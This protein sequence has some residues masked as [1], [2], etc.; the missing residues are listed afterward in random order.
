M[1]L[2]VAPPPPS[3]P[4]GYLENTPLFFGFYTR[5]SLDWHCL[6]TP[7][8]YLA[9]ILSILLLSFIL[10]VR[11]SVRSPQGSVFQLLFSN[12]P[13]TRT[14]VGY[15]HTWMLRKRYSM[16]VSYKIFCGWDFTIQDPDSASLKHGCIRNDLKV[17][18]ASTPI[19]SAYHL[20]TSVR[21][22]KKNWG[23]KM[24]SR[25]VSPIIL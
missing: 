16:N 10:L 23:K 25:I 17:H 3:S 11:R 18:L 22:K 8:L 7:L 21:V 20:K 9:G 12:L 15:K 13:T 14:M 1:L 24:V 2:N 5:G 19:A 6:T 4:Q